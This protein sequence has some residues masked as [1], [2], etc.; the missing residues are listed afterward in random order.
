MRNHYHLVPETPS[1]NLVSASADLTNWL[2]LTNFPP[3]PVTSLQYADTL[4][5]SF[6]NRLYRTVWVP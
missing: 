2:T 5:P 1:A 6:L 4:A 3:L